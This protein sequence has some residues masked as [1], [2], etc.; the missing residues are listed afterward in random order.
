[1]A[2]SSNVISSH[3]FFPNNFNPNGLFEAIFPLSQLLTHEIVIVCV[4]SKLS[5]IFALVQ[6]II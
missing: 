4:C 1:M 6:N 5:M 3:S 2:Q